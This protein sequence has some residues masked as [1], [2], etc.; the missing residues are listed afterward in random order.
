[1]SPGHAAFGSS[2]TPL[3][4]A[5]Q[6]PGHYA[7]ASQAAAGGGAQGGG[8]GG[9]K[10]PPPRMGGG[11]GGGGGAGSFSGRTSH[12]MSAG[13]GLVGRS[14][15]LVGGQYNGYKGRVKHETPSHVQLELDA[16]SGR[17]VTVEKK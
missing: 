5:P 1:M 17:I 13:G 2:R 15:R 7:L 9:F 16:I 14:V 6:S 8:F 12:G 4:F 3:A 10:P 11:P